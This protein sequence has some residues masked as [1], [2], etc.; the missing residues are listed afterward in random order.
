[1]S[2]RSVAVH[3]IL[4]GDVAALTQLLDIEPQLARIYLG[5]PWA[6]R[7]LLHV[8]TDWPGHRPFV[9]QVIASL[10]A[11]G[12]DADAPF[13]GGHRET[14]LHWAASCDDVVAAMALLDAGA[15][16]DATGAALGDGSGTP[17]FDAVAYRCW[18]VA[19]HLVARGATTDGWSQAALGMSGQ[20]AERI[21]GASQGEL[22]H[23]LWAAAH[24]GQ[25]SSVRMLLAAG[26]DAR[27]RAVWD[28][29]TAPAAAAESARAGTPGAVEVAQALKSAGG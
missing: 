4:C 6:G 12:A 21:G 17:L 26:A 28:G 8:A 9:A 10:V 24:G 27:W 23:W 22:D 5:D 1:M 11:A 2:E 18:K 15:N 16:I 13:A 7:T 3:A 25:V 14:A 20:L 19:R 29:S